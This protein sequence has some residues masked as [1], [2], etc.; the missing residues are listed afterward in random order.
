MRDDLRD[1]FQSANSLGKTK[2]K[3]LLP[4]LSRVK[5]YLL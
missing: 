5:K 1:E 2:K 3:Y 4:S